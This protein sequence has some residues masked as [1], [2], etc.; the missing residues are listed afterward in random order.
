M[1]SLIRR[2]RTFLKSNQI[3]IAAGDRALQYTILL[4]KCYNVRGMHIPLLISL[5][6]FRNKLIALHI[7]SDIFLPGIYQT[8]QGEGLLR[9]NRRQRGCQG[10]AGQYDPR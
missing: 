2:F 5:C 4:G 10:L 6:T 1:W 3:V 7:M 9:R 8:I